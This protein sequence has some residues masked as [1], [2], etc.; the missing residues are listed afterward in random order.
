MSGRALRW[1][2]SL[3]AAGPRANA[4]APRLTIIRQHRI[5]RA[6]ERPLYRLG[7]SETIFESQVA[8]CVAAGLTPVTVADGLAWLGRGEQ[9]QRVAFTFDDG[10]A[11]NA[12]LAV[13]ILA[14]HGAKGTFYLAA[15]LMQEQRAPWWDELAWCLTEA[16][17][18]STSI[19]FGG[20]GVP[21]ELGTWAGQKAALGALLPLLRVSPDEQR[22]RLDALR[23][24][25]GVSAPAPCALADWTLAARFAEA[26]MEVGAHTL[27]HPF[28]TLVPSAS[29]AGEIADSAALI[30]AR[31]GAPVTGLAYPNGDHDESVVRAAQ[32]SGLTY[33]VTTNAGDCRDLLAPFRLPRRAL[34][35]GAC[36]G[37]TARFSAHML[38][39]ELTGAFDP[40]RRGR[41]EVG[42]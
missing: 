41:V 27:S 34:T 17:R 24:A 8:A 1:L 42:T 5:Y 29:Q 38:R 14:R 37:P 10:Y 4:G 39:A 12:T 28:L 3:V 30:R 9:G 2:L 31:L 22:A 20:Q 21:L 19:D 16:T 11:D 15:G 7:V 26:R 40:L 23:A 36:M 25:T 18:K 13:P 32:A 33:A 6:G 35:E